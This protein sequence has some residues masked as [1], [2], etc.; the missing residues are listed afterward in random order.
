MEIKKTF[1]ILTVERQNLGDETNSDYRI[2][3]NKI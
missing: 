1:L 3:T 2:T